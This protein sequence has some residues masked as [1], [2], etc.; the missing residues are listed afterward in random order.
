MSPLF[1]RFPVCWDPEKP[2]NHY[3]SLKQ[4]WKES[5]RAKLLIFFLNTHRLE[6][7]VKGLFWVMIRK[8]VVTFVRLK[9]HLGHFSE[10]KL[11]WQP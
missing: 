5:V 2:A 4:N 10:M 3:Q 7:F 11:D 8:F 1:P 6:S 9:C